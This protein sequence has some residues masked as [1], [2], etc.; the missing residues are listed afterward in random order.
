MSLYKK[1]MNNI[2]LET[3]IKP[4]NKKYNTDYLII[5]INYSLK[6]NIL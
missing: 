1:I 3:K 5:R 6:Y 4:N 2:I